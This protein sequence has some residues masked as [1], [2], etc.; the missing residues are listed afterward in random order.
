MTDETEI[1]NILQTYSLEEI[2]EL[3]DL[4]EAD[5]LYFLEKQEF[6]TLPTPKPL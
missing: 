5:A 4:T 2:L 3:N 1:E 6:V